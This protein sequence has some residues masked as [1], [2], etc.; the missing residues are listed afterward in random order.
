[1]SHDITVLARI[2]VIAA[3]IFGALGKFLRFPRADRLSLAREL[4]RGIVATIVVFGGIPV[5][6]LAAWGAGSLW[7][8]SIIFLTLRA[9]G[10]VCLVALFVTSVLYLRK[11]FPRYR[12]RENTTTGDSQS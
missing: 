7:R 9:V 3:L 4:V 8:S 5:I 11:S 1:M 10:L 12:S 6:V 2:F